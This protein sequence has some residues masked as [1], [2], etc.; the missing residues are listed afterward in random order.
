MGFYEKLEKLEI[1]QNRKKFL[2]RSYSL[3]GKVLVLRLNKNILKYKKKIGGACLHILP[4]VH[5]VVLEKGIEGETR[6]PKIEIL[7]GCKE[8]D[9]TQTIMKEHGCQFL[10]D[11][12]KVMWSKGNKS[13]RERM[14]QLAKGNETVVDMFAGIGYF[15]IFLA[16]KAKKVF[17]LEINPQA[18]EYL[19]K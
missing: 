1:P 5:T 12:S 11:V 17:A 7:A 15:S 9:S 10:L 19:Q 3:V 13:E 14:M 6:K 8:H 4:Y 16:K 18:V 2:P